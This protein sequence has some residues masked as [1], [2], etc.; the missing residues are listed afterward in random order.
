MPDAAKPLEVFYSYA[1]KD[2]DLRDELDKHLSALKIQGVIS[3]WHDRNINAG[4]EWE[5]Q[6]SEHLNSADIILLLVSSY[7]LGS[8]YCVSKEM[9]RA[10]ERH[11]SG[12]A[13]VI[14]IIL[15]PVDW[16]DMEI[17]KLQALPTD[18]KPVSSWRDKHGAFASIAKGIRK[19]SKEIEELRGRKTG[20]IWMVPHPQNV[21][22]TGRE[23]LLDDLRK[24]LTSGQRAALTQAIHGLGE[25]EKRKRPSSMPIAMLAN[26]MQCFGCGLKNLPHLQPILQA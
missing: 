13:R 6:I 18:G 23:E 26:M 3:G 14:P 2:E 21:N 10:L 4:T 19:A 9:K 22:F 11:T 25:S 17:R 8:A 12:E 1:H 15:R 5:Q 20:K 7:F 16:E 24:K